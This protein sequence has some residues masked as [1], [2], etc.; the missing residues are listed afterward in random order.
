MNIVFRLCYDYKQ[1]QIQQPANPDLDLSYKALFFSK[2]RTIFAFLDP[3][4]S[5]L[6]EHSMTTLSYPIEVKQKIQQ[7]GI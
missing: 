4:P 5:H 3:D 7:Y 1:T 6:S 2:F